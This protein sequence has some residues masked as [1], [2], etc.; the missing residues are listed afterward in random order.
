MTN[1]FQRHEPYVVVRL[2]DGWCGKYESEDKRKHF[3]ALFEK[4][5]GR[6]AIRNRL[7]ETIRSHYERLDRIADDAAR[8]S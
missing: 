3:W 8:A 4:A 6:D 5:G 7:A 2:V 1:Q